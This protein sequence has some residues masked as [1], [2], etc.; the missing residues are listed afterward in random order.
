MTTV[1]RFLAVFVVCGCCCSTSL[2]YADQHVYAYPVPLK[3]GDQLR[4]GP[5]GDSIACKEGTTFL[6]VDLLPEAKF[7]HPTLYVLMSGG[8]AKSF[9][10]QWWPELNGERVLYGLASPL[11]IKSPSKPAAEKQVA[12]AVKRGDETPQIA[13]G[14]S[15]D[16]AKIKV[17]EKPK[18]NVIR[19]RRVDAKVAGCFVSE[20]GRYDAVAGDLIELEYTYPVVPGGEPKEVHRETDKGA[21]YVSPLGI[22]HLIVPKLVG[23]GTYVFYFEKKHEGKGTAFVVIDN[24]K[25]EYVFEDPKKQ[26]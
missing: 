8:E 3:A 10:G 5:E 24:V 19:P 9:K 16:A 26:K 21:V 7:A 4:D 2:L 23:T 11:V 15:K 20:P 1:A 25:Y 13:S 17:C 12:E 22:R 6:W 18:G 14:H